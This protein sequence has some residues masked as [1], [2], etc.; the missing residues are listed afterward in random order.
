MNDRELRLRKRIDQLTDERDKALDQRDR[1]RIK[2][3]RLRG[4]I[5]DLTRSRDLWRIRALRKPVK[6]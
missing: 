4:R 5:Y 1:L 2:M 3:W 6:K